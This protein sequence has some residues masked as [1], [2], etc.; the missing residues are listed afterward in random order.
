MVRVEEN[1]GLNQNS[2]LGGR[3]EKG[4]MRDQGRYRSDGPWRW[5]GESTLGKGVKGDAKCGASWVEMVNK[6]K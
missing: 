1:A 5:L 4:L 6:G 3:G 2:G